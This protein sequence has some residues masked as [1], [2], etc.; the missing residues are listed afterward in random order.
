[1][2]AASARS[3]VFAASHSVSASL[4]FAGSAPSRI[5]AAPC[6]R[7]SAFEC[8]CVGAESVGPTPRFAWSWSPAPNPTLSAVPRCESPTVGV[9][10]RSWPTF[11]SFPQSSR[12][13]NA[14]AVSQRQSPRTSPWYVALIRHFASFVLAVVLERHRSPS[15][16]LRFDASTL[17]SLRHRRRWIDWLFSWQDPSGQLHLVC[18]WLLSSSSSSR[19]L[20]LCHHPRHHHRQSSSRRLL[21]RR[22]RTAPWRAPLPFLRLAFVSPTR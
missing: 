8:Y 14:T 20:L 6:S 22:R 2:P 12:A 11:C 13:A 3:F 10:C 7:W 4:R 1:M 5:S 9:L 18:L 15:S 21:R 16:T 19:R 17:D